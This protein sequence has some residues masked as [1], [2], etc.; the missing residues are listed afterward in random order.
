MNFFP[1]QKLTRIAKGS[2]ISATW[3][4]RIVDVL[5]ARL[6]AKIPRMQKGSVISAAW[7][8][9]I[10]TEVARQTHGARV[11]GGMDDAY[12]YRAGKPR[13]VASKSIRCLSRGEVITATW[14]NSLVDALNELMSIQTYSRYFYYPDSSSKEVETTHPWKVTAY[15][16]A[17]AETWKLSIVAAHRIYL[18]S[19]T[20]GTISG[21]RQGF[22]SLD[23]PDYDFFVY[24]SVPETRF[25]IG[26][27]MQYPFEAASN[28]MPWVYHGLAPSVSIG[29]MPKT[30]ESPGFLVATGKP[31]YDD[32]GKISGAEIE[33]IMMSDTTVGWSCIGDLENG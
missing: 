8:N 26:S 33:Q 4:N 14:L 28:G 21:G 6:S 24:A 12:F 29:R 7:L 31:V 15:Y 9:R 32:D 18:S 20:N 3:L 10:A 11:I 22:L 25:P 13:N 27:T 1:Q 23:M 5:N 30:D 2:V 17:D 19:G 16:D